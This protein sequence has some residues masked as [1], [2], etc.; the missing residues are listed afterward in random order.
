MTLKI[1]FQIL[2][3]FCTRFSQFTLLFF[4]KVVRNFQLNHTGRLLRAPHSIYLNFCFS[5]TLFFLCA[6]SFFSLQTNKIFGIFFLLRTSFFA[7]FFP[8]YPLFFSST[9]IELFFTRIDRK[10]LFSNSKTKKF[11]AAAAIEIIL[12]HHFQIFSFFFFFFLQY[13]GG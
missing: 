13:D 1:A 12:I 7:F 10:K 5:I 9:Q 11:F 2:T 8:F 4:D 6:C 3:R